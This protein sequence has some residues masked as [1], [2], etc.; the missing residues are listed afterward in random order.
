MT[1][2]R[3][4]NAR[5]NPYRAASPSSADTGSTED[6][7]SSE[8]CS[9]GSDNQSKCDNDA[10]LRKLSFSGKLQTGG[11]ALSIFD[12]QPRLSRKY[13]RSRNDRAWMRRAGCVMSRF[14]SAFPDIEYDIAWTVD[15]LN[16]IAWR[17]RSKRH[18]RLYG[19]L[20][21]HKLI[22]LEACAVLFAHE[23]GHHCG[24][25]P[26]DVDYNWMSCECQADIWAAQHGV[27]LAMG[28]A[29]WRRTV[30]EGAKQILAFE[31]SLIESSMQ[32]VPNETELDCLDHAPPRQRY[33]TLLTSL[34]TADDC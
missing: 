16:G 34:D 2:A 21:R 19:G 33:R 12:P 32:F 29:D 8:S 27:R 1:L 13:L 15:L 6:H 9:S 7:H 28:D 30:R 10:V 11:M 4:S 5:Q 14:Q 26:R 18:V 31:E 25:L 24:G 17:E 22:K 23:T 20:L 3:F